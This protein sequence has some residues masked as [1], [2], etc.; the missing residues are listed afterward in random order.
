MNLHF[1]KLN[2]WASLFITIF[3]VM[4]LVV[5]ELILKQSLFEKHQFY[6]VVAVSGIIVFVL[7][8]V[9]LEFLFNTYAKKQIQRI[10]N[11]ISDVETEKKEDLD[12]EKLEEKVSDMKEKSNTEIDTMKAMER[13]R[14]EYI[15][16]VSHEMKTP[17]FSIQ[18]YV[19]TLIDGG[20]EDLQIRDKYLKRI[21]KSVQR[22]FNIVQDLDMINKYESG[23]IRLEVS[24][25]DINTLV[26]EVVE[27]MEMEAKK[28]N[29]QIMVQKTRP[30]LMVSADKQKIFQILMNLVSN[31]IYYS[32]KEKAK[33][34]I[35]TK[36][37][38]GKIKITVEDNGIGIKPEVL[39][40]IFE[41]FY[42]AESSRN[43]RKGGSG[44]G[45]AIVKHIL[46]A[47]DEKIKVK[48]VYLEGTKFSFSLNKADD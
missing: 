30:I 36:K 6:Y 45:L 34:I 11:M 3:I 44:L 29:A 4:V 9:V 12:F 39:P 31:A 18:G 46:E 17:L 15:G 38:K 28:K 20:V 10:S 40:R 16:N 33:I 37:V 7:S 19:S 27:L 24:S 13:Y 41:R 43:R 8:Y 1:R 5:F 21:D 32:N 42:R 23:E 25:F 26:D 47:H 14:K 22:L 2:F 48:S 35:T